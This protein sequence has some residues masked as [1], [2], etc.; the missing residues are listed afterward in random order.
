MDTF[1]REAYV[2]M[3]TASA[4]SFAGALSADGIDYERAGAARGMADAVELF[5]LAVPSLAVL[6]LVLEKLRR[7]RLPRTYVAVRGSGIE[8]WTDRATKDGRIFVSTESE[9]FVELPDTTIS[10]DTLR[11]ALD[12]GRTPES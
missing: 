7:A 12:Q 11:H 8:I 5:V 2:E 4:A 6:A 3:P 9:E 1:P 10:A